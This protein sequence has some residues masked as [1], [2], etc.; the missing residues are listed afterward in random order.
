MTEIM[1]NALNPP[2]E[3]PL[4]HVALTLV[5]GPRI[6]YPLMTLMMHR[7]ADIPASRRPSGMSQSSVFCHFAT[8]AEAV[9]QTT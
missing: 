7:L 9:A 3:K 4:P 2:A 5:S 1:A 8:K 6:T